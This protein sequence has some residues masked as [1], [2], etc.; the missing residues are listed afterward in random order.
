MSS[1]AL[2]NLKQS[3]S[4]GNSLSDKIIYR[5]LKNNKIT[6]N[7]MMQRYGIKEAT[8]KKTLT[9]IKDRLWEMNALYITTPYD[10]G[11]VLRKLL[12]SGKVKTGERYYYSLQKESELRQ[13]WS[14]LDTLY[15]EGARI[16]QITGDDKLAVQISE[17][18]KANAARL[19]Q[20]TLLYSDIIT[21]MIR[22]EGYVIRKPD[23]QAYAARL[24]ELEHRARETEHHVLIH[25]ALHLKYL[26]YVRYNN[27]PGIVF[28]VISE[29]RRNA[30]R[31]R[32]IMND[33]TRALALNNYVNFLVIYNCFGSPEPYI[34]ELQ[35]VIHAGG[36]MAVINFYYAMLE[37]CLFE[38]KDEALDKWLSQL[39]QVEDN[40]KFYQYRFIIYSIK[41]FRDDDFQAFNEHVNS[42]YSSPA[43]LDFPD[44]SIT[45]RLLE[46][47]I[48]IVKCKHDLVM[49][50]AEAL[51]L[52]IIRNVN[53]DRH[54]DEKRMIPLFLK[55]NEG[56]KKMLNEFSQFQTSPYR[57]VT[58]IAKSVRRYLK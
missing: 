37:Y 27:V 50:R 18:R 14:K 57:N 10:D 16:A 33:M 19:Y 41:A 22:L 8:L 56:N 20:F 25:G 42:F 26:F 28:S 35:R 15:T 48:L 36:E 52:Y 6:R 1:E 40:S 4:Q 39:K 29:Q 45:L 5:I 11:Y 44:L 38:E 2:A 21:E 24:D 49:A 30:I 53:E 47:I 51:R 31:Y 13:E 7:D 17:K 12:L 9:L 46:I 58:F 54:R 3:V 23:L 43:H 32:K 55:I 34:K